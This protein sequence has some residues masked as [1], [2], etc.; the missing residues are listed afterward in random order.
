MVLF[1]NG[2]FGPCL[3]LLRFVH[4]F[5][6]FYRILVKFRFW[7]IHLNFIDPLS[8]L[9]L[10]TQIFDV[11]MRFCILFFVSLMEIKVI[12]I[13]LQFLC[14][15]PTKHVILLVRMIVLR[16]RLIIFMFFILFGQKLRKIFQDFG[17]HFLTDIIQ[18]LLLLH[19]ELFFLEWIHYLFI[20]LCWILVDTFWSFWMQNP[21][22]IRICTKTVLKTL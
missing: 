3:S 10:L 16:N 13:S 19:L 4:S 22:W 5:K 21:S 11:R 9:V 2:S 17:I 8:R 15:Q 6:E 12:M 20:Y 14:A 18:H 7:L 1:V